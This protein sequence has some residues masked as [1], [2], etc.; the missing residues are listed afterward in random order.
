M[1]HHALVLLVLSGCSPA[2][3]G[4]A[5]YRVTRTADALEVRIGPMEIA[6][7][8]DTRQCVSVLLK[9]D[10][11]VRGFSSSYPELPQIGEMVGSHHVLI[12]A[13][14]A[15]EDAPD[16]S[17]E[18]CPFTNSAELGDDGY[19]VLWG[20]TVGPGALT[21]P[22]GAA[23]VLPAGTALWFEL[24][25]LN[26]G[27]A[28]VST[29]AE[30]RL[31]LAAS[32]APV[33]QASFSSLPFVINPHET[34][35][36]TFEVPVPEDA[37]VVALLPHAH[38]YLT[39]YTAYYGD[40]VLLS[41]QSLEMDPVAVFDPPRHVVAGVPFRVTCE[42]LNPT[43]EPIAWPNEMCAGWAYVLE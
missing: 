18:P 20:A 31:D 26:P 27:D 4:S 32:A 24:H 34:K 10:I 39:R 2:T 30:F 19:R 9:E 40:E 37:D 21:F 22:D 15:P 29:A 13:T 1:R 42:Y 25:F 11:R 3:E 17:F 35:T 43:D 36:V 12:A 33:T 6:S 41:T 5:T 14:T 38:Q 28:P 7:G 16:V 23:Y 8:V